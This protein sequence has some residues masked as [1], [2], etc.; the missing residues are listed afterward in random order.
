MGNFPP[1]ARPDGPGVRRFPRNADG[2]DFVVGDL[3][4]MYAVLERALES[5][6]FAP[7]RDRLFS[8]GDLIDPGGSQRVDGR[9]AG[10]G[11]VSPMPRQP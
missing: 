4:G 1:M 9:L 5:V 10:Q 8:V 3:H 7:D 2:R 11:V 6:G